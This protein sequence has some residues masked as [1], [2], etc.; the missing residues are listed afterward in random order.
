MTGGVGLPA[1]LFQNPDAFVAVALDGNVTLF[2]QMLV[3]FRE[4]PV[5]KSN[6]NSPSSGFVQRFALTASDVQIYVF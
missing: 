5:G 6:M 4:T 3:E 2:V 1:G